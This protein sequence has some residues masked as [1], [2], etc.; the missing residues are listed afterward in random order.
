VNFGPTVRAIDIRRHMPRTC[1][2]GQ[3]APMTLRNAPYEAIIA[4]VRR[5]FEAVGRDGGLVI[6]TAGS[7][8][9]GTTFDRI[10]CF[11]WAV[12]RYARY[13]GKTFDDAA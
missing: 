9:A 5:D 2:H 12:D 13:D 7:I 10:R 11:M 4:E 8:A 1:I 3:V 6:T